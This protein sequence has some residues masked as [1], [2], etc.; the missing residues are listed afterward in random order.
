MTV[1]LCEK[2]ITGGVV[3]VVAIVAVVVEMIDN[4]GNGDSNVSK[5]LSKVD[6]DASK[7]VIKSEK[8]AIKQ[9]AKEDNKQSLNPLP[10]KL[11][12]LHNQVRAK[13]LSDTLKGSLIGISTGAALSF[14]LF[15]RK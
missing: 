3:S 9:S 10:D 11:T 8:E 4:K 12:S 14:L 15:R 5:E 7:E 13:I 2:G 1:V 6:K